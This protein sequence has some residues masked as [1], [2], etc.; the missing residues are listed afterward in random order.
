MS[1]DLFIHW[2]KSHRRVIDQLR[3]GAQ[4]VKWA[5]LKS[6]LLIQPS[7]SDGNNGRRGTRL[8][9]QIYEKKKMLK[10]ERPGFSRPFV[11]QFFFSIQDDIAPKPILTSASTYHLRY[12]CATLV[13]VSRHCTDKQY[14]WKMAN[15]K[16]KK[17]FILFSI[18]RI[19]IKPV[20]FGKK[21]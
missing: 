8:L 5:P 12:R 4:H 2:G 6:N 9:R 10:K 13:V 14:W 11:V 1:T 3:D 7:C 17:R 15:E 20:L 21:W 16:C 19:I 18:F